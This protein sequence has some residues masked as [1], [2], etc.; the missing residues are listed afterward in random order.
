MKKVNFSAILIIVIS[1]LMCSLTSCES[2]SGR[3]ARLEKRSKNITPKISKVDSLQKVIDNLSSTDFD[4]KVKELQKKPEFKDAVFIS[5]LET[6]QYF[7]ILNKNKKRFV[8]QELIYEQHYDNKDGSCYSSM[9]IILDTTQS[10]I[11][12]VFISEHGS[13]AD[14]DNKETYF[15]DEYKFF[16]L[17]KLK[18][19]YLIGEKTRFDY[20][21]RNLK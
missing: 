9:K 14:V 10:V 19:G 6:K 8:C 2:Y 1:V 7:D 20:I 12:V 16:Y 3:K 11:P 18:V 21:L 17:P 13:I 4:L 5:P 15:N